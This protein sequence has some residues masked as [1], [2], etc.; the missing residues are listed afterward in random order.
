[1]IDYVIVRSCDRNDIFITKTMTS[2]DECWTDHRLIRSTMCFALRYKQRNAK[3]QKR[4]KYNVGRL[5]L[6]EKRVEFQAKMNEALLNVETTNVKCFWDGL[7]TAVK[8]TCDDI[9]GT[10]LRFSE[11]WFDENDAE[12]QQYNRS[13]T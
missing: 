5:S 4:T 10:Q 2:S 3:K 13:K 6:P 12:I 8:T 11:D 9:L 7:K 1:M